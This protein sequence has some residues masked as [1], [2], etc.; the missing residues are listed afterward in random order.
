MAVHGERRRLSGAGA[1]AALAILVGIAVAFV[2]LPL[3]GLFA[4]ALAARGGPGA[5]RTLLDDP[6][7]RTALANS[8]LQGGLSAAVAGLAG[9]P[10][11]L[12]LGR[13]TFR[14]SGLLRSFLLIPFL[15]PSLVVITGLVQLFGRGGL[16]STVLPAAG[17]LGSGLAGIVLVNVFFNASMVALFTA[18][19]I[20]NAPREPEE[21][22]ALLGAS[23]VRVF[24][25]LWGPLSAVGAAA[26]M[27]LTFLL[28]AMGF[29]A[30]LVVCGA[31]CYTLEVRIWSLDQVLGQPTEAAVVGLAAVLVL[32]L[33]ALLYLL[34]ARAAGRRTGRR[35]ERGRPFPWRERR[36]WPLAAYGTLFV[37]GI[38]VLLG[39][40][41]LR[42]VAFP[43]APLGAGW[44]RLFSPAI[45]QRLGIS[46]AAA[47][48][49]SLLYAG[50]AMIL[51]LLLAIA[52]AYARRRSRRAGVGLDYL[53]FLPVLVS[54]VL[55][56]F[57]LSAFWLPRLGGAA[58][59]W[60]LIIVSQSLIAWPF[61]AQAL[62]GGVE[63]LDRAPAESARV[64]GRGPF[65]AFLDVELPRAR[66]ALV[67]ASLFG[68]ALGLGEFT[69]TYFLV[70]PAFTTLPVELLRLGELR[71]TDAAAALAGLLVVVSAASFALLSWGG[72]RVEL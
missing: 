27:L 62:R 6:L 10:M 8:L 31:R 41:L 51:V 34:L 1:P 43:G 23:P 70:R 44:E 35:P 29:A 36:L 56:A 24:R 3:G 55:L 18:T 57:G 71:L 45:A 4:P 53:L 66:P 20:E 68:F 42:S 58:A 28:S 52:T 37:A 9:Y 5:L 22:A 59:S 48:V 50:T 72:E 12:L 63:R 38:L 33:P 40:V 54:P 16:V 32:S 19:A 39:S 61:A 15:L 64:L 30:P 2:L 69:A 65:S 60:G 46:T 17:L 21:A 25:E 11:G 47:L 67:A 7:T 14:G 13:Y 49:N 26:G